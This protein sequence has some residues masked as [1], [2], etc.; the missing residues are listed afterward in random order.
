MDNF[1]TRFDLTGYRWSLRYTMC[2]T[3]GQKQSIPYGLLEGQ[4]KKFLSGEEAS[5]LLPQTKQPGKGTQ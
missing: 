2:D 5:N 3:N 4:L 1:S